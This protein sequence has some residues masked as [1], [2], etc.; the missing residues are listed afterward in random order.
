MSAQPPFKFTKDFR[1]PKPEQPPPA[2]HVQAGLEKLRA[3][4]GGPVYAYDQ[5]QP[6]NR[7]R[8]MNGELLQGGKYRRKT[9]KRSSRRRKTRRRR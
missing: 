8:D 1:K 5:K 2:D 9:R 7:P 3:R 4:R 6:D